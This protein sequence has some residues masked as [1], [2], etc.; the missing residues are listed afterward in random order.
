MAETLEEDLN[1]TF[2]VGTPDG[3]TC[4][5][6]PPLY[7]RK[8]TK[9]EAVLA[10][11]S[12]AETSIFFPELQKIGALLSKEGG[13]SSV[14]CY[15]AQAVCVGSAAFGLSGVDAAGA[16][17]T[18]GM[19]EPNTLIWVATMLWST[20]LALGALVPCSARDALCTGGA[21]EKL[22]A[23]E[24]M[25]SEQDS[26]TLSRWRGSL[27]VLSVWAAL[28][29]LGCFVSAVLNISMPLQN[30]STFSKRIQS[31][32]YGLVSLVAALGMTGWWTSMF[33]ASTI[34]RDA[35]VE[36]I[37]NVRLTNP[38]SEAWNEKV[39]QPALSLNDKM[40]LLSYGWSGGLAGVGGSCWFMA[41][42]GFAQ[43]INAPLMRGWDTSLGE[44]PGTSFRNNV[45]SM[46]IMS[47]LPFVLAMDIADTSTWCDK[48]MDELND[49]RI[50]YGL[51]SHLKIRWL[52]TSLKQLVRLL[53]TFLLRKPASRA[54]TRA[55]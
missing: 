13:R 6:T 1:P 10:R 21:L 7:A 5:A 32:T 31:A 52:E 53:L 19:D 22:K 35:V 38:T 17:Q 28:W 51:E 4:H 36:V 9:T 43:V 29:G 48:L 40:N 8:R 2:T 54:L 20:A 11:D 25:I 50:N 55:R 41:L 30:H 49:A 27:G 18:A 15:L 39:A 42:T 12:D 23:G 26:R 16:A 14:V 24:A 34:C 45:L 3:T 47:L 37:K 46:A 33:I 44:S